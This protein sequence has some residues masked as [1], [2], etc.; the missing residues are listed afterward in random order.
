MISEDKHGS[1]PRPLSAD[2]LRQ[3]DVLSKATVRAAEHLGLP[4]TVLA[5]VLGLSEASVSRL[6]NRRFDLP[7]G[8]KAYELAQHLVRLFRGLDAITGGDDAASRSWMRGENLALRGRP[9]DLIQSVAGLVATLAYVD[10]SRA[11]I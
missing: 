3:A 7:P 5:R 4:N 10:R 2:P 1:L 9:I 6:K 11:R 8:S